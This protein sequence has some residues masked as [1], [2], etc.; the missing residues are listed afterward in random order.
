MMKP[1]VVMIFGLELDEWNVEGCIAHFGVGNNWATL[2][3]IESHNPK[4]G[5][6]TRLLKCAKKYYEKQGKLVG[7]TVALNQVM[8]RIYLK[9]GIKEYKE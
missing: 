6:A 3:Y 1:K 9:L 7:G 2:Y 8:E 4:E 5:H